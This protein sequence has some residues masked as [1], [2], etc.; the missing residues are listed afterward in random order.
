ME[1]TNCQF[2]CSRG[3]LKSCH[4]FNQNIYSSCQESTI[5]PLAVKLGDIVYVCNYAL[6]HFVFTVLPKIQVPF[7]LVSGD[8]DN[9]IPNSIL[10]AS[11]VLLTSPKV[12]HWFCQNFVPENEK[13]SNPKITPIPIGLDYHT[14]AQNSSSWGPKISPK[15]QEE[16]IMN[17][18]KNNSKP[19]S[20]RI[21][22]I[23]ST[24][25]FFLNRGDRQE[26]YYQIPKHLIDYEPNQISRLET[27]TRQIEYAF[28]AS[29]YGGGPDCHRTWE[30]LLLGCIP[31]IKRDK[32][33]SLFENEEYK[34]PVLLV[35][36]WSD[37][38]EELL[39]N[40]IEK[41]NKVVKPF[42]ELPQLQLKYWTDKF[43]K[44]SQ[45]IK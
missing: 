35:D 42:H 39:K 12:L 15:V 2:I 1:E 43:E 16:E 7:V 20:Q 30:A 29:P 21:P 37:I 10:Q 25:H 31:I 34:L 32:I 4:H 22:K 27:H 19:L 40:T 9:E 26:A 45:I 17:L 41:F 44:I 8:S 33:D 38:N 18:I 28:V 14:M 3:L 5:N 6:N 13:F 23:Y 24:F 11:R 36:K